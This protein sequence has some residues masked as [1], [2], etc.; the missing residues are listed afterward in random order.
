MN[1]YRRPRD[2]M[3]NIYGTSSQDIILRISAFNR[4]SIGRHTWDLL[5][6]SP[7][8]VLTTSQGRHTGCPKTS[9]RTSIC[10]HSASNGRSHG[11][12]RD[13]DVRPGMIPLILAGRPL[14]VLRTSL[15]Y[16]GR[17][18][19]IACNFVPVVIC[20]I[21]TSQISHNSLITSCLR[22]RTR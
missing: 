17:Y 3:Q 13:V 15:C 14:D 8:H 21:P 5:Q 6:T 9:Y 16:V 7:K 11:R 2:V 22:S 12:P 1:S 20:S 19:C 4:T 18:L 10:G